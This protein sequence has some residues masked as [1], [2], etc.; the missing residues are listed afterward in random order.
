MVFSEIQGERVAILH[1]ETNK[2]VK[3]FIKLPTRECR[4][5]SESRGGANYVMLHHAFCAGCTIYGYRKKYK[6][7]SPKTTLNDLQSPTFGLK[8]LEGDAVANQH[9]GAGP[10]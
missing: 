10:S 5:Q 9:Q 8:N 1:Q 7:T 3:F 2:N 6:G 4:S